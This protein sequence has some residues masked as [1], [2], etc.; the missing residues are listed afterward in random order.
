VAIIFEFEDGADVLVD[1]PRDLD[2]LMPTAKEWAE[3]EGGGTV[4]LRDS[5]DGRIITEFFVGSGQLELDWRALRGAML[6]ELIGYY[7]DDDEW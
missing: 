5:E 1:R 4:T 7:E 6:D 3:S 2:I